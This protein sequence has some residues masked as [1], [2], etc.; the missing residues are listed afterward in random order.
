VSSVGWVPFNARYWRFTSK[1]GIAEVGTPGNGVR[2]SP[3]LFTKVS[4]RGQEAGE[5]PPLAWPDEHVQPA[6]AAQESLWVAGEQRTG[7]AG[8][9][10]HRPVVARSDE[11]AVPP[12]R[13]LGGVGPRQL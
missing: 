7:S 2:T 6:I 10:A 12:Q 1:Y 8:P 11:H 4:A 9:L 13:G 5:R 3:S